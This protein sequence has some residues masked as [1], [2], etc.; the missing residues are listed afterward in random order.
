MDYLVEFRVGRD[1]T[2][3]VL[4]GEMEYISFLDSVCN[5]ILEAKCFLMV[6]HVLIIIN[7]TG[8]QLRREND[9]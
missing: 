2:S 6:Q 7:M 5:W 3:C 9:F 8:I 1:I 4:H